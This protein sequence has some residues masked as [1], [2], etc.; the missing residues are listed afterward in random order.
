MTLAHKWTG[1]AWVMVYGVTFCVE[2]RFAEN[3]IKCHGSPAH[4]KGGAGFC[5]HHHDFACN[6][7]GRDNAGFVK[8]N[9]VWMITSEFVWG[10]R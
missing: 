7:L 1:S 9:P 3:V 5:E 4:N 2:K 10:A 8:E 6:H